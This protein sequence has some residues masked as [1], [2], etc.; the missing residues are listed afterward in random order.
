[1]AVTDP[2]E[3]SDGVPVPEGV[4]EGVGVPVIDGVPLPEP[5]I[6][7]EAVPVTEGEPV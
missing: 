7:M 6:D 2:L 5:V 1:V 3:V 4:F